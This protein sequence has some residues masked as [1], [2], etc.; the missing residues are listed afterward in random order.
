MSKNKWLGLLS[1]LSIL[2]INIIIKNLYVITGIF[3]L[4]LVINIFTNKNVRQTL[5]KIGVLLLLYFITCIIQIFIV[6]EGR[7]L[8]KV[9]INVFITNFT[10][11][12]T[13][14][15][16]YVACANFLR[17]A[18][19]FMISTIITSQNLINSS[20]NKYQ[21]VIKNVIELVPESLIIIRKRLKIKYFI[22]YVLKEIYSK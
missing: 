4:L 3:F 15:G 16:L 19:L 2:L 13:K 9:N 11:Y 12:V 8:W 18:N 1:L 22:R 14:E 5:K 20:R 7:V 17:M 10:V 21:N 6:Q